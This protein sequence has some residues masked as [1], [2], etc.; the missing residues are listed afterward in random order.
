MDLSKKKKLAE[1]TFNVG[2]DRII[3]LESRLAEI[4]D[5]ITKQDIRDLQKS[6]AILIKNKKGRKT[7]ERKKGRST[8]NIRKK[9]RKRKKEYIIITRKLRAYL[10][11]SGKEG[12]LTKEYLKGIKK[13][14]RNRDFKSKAHL[15]EY[16][17]GI[18]K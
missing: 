12:E 2:V 4:K 3:F 1:K 16:L 9:S 15:K 8:G 10:K 7:I 18:Q 13:K 11:S 14:I 5:A 17:E 6:G